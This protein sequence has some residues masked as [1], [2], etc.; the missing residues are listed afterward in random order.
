[1]AMAKPW[2]AGPGMTLTPISSVWRWGGLPAREPCG[3]WPKKKIKNVRVIQ[4]EAQ[5]VFERFFVQKSIDRIRSF[6]PIP[7]PKDKHENRRLF[8]SDFLRLA[9]SRLGDCGTIQVVTD[10][11]PFMTW[12]LD[13]APDTGFSVVQRDIPAGLD[14]KYERKWREGGQE[15]FHEIILT[16]T[17]HQDVPLTED[18]VL[19]NHRLK[20]FDPERFEP[21]DLLGPVTI[22]FKE[23][24]FDP[25]RE[26]AMIRAFLVENR[27][28]Q[29]IWIRIFRQDDE[30]VLGLDH[31]NHVVPTE[32]VRWPWNG[33]AWARN[34]KEDGAAAD[35]KG[36]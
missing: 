20:N 17:D 29:E 21:K 26:K 32:G 14:T 8:S 2:R 12:V 16:K 11:E 13:Q 3:D 22:K 33:P 5:I 35:S 31:G 1:M 34:Y 27:L 19:Q 6:F 4:L 36:A 7:W 28:V 25:V 10:F 24:L 18:E 30:W 15:I 9:N 23:F